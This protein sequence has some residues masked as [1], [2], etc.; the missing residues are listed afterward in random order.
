[1]D[2]NM[3]QLKMLDDDNAHKKLIGEVLRKMSPGSDLHEMAINLYSNFSKKNTLEVV[4]SHIAMGRNLSDPSL[5]PDK[6]I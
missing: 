5:F 6:N 4:W 1:M 3:S 2:F